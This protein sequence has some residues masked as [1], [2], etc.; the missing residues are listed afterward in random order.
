MK[1]NSLSPF[2]ELNTIGLCGL[3]CLYTTAN[4]IIDPLPTIKVFIIYP[5]LIF[6]S[7][8]LPS[9]FP[10]KTVSGHNINGLKLQIKSQVVTILY[11]VI[12]SNYPFYI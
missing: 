4:Y 6:N 9:L 5:V 11:K 10:T 8:I 12:V 3:L 7:I 1:N 2:L